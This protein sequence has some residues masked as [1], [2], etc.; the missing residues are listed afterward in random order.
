MTA[1]RFALTIIAALA[2]EGQTTW[3][4]SK[5][6]FAQ[7]AKPYSSA[8]YNADGYVGAGG[9]IR[10]GGLGCSAYVSVVLHR[11]RY[12]MVWRK[13]YSL[14]VHQRYGDVIARN[15]G[16]KSA[17]RFRA[18]SLLSVKATRK[19]MASGKLKPN[20]LYLF[21]VR[22]GKQGHVGFLR[23]KQ[24]GRLIQSHYSG[25]KQYNGLATGDFR[26]WLRASRYRTEPIQLFRIRE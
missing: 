20:G 6:S 23:V 5:T 13:H 26:R 24:D 18:S 17:G 1:T 19:L 9:A 21:N 15:F 22:R 25:M 3:Q 7:A 4:R 8:K 11:M 2:S 14:K 10:G 16:L 12:G